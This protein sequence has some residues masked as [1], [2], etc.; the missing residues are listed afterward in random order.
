M[1]IKATCQCGFTVTAK[2]ALAGKRVACPRCQKALQIPK[3]AT[4]A[5]QAQTASPKIA[6]LLDDMGVK[7]VP[8]G[9]VCSACGEEMDATAVLCVNCGYNVTTGQY[10][11]TY[12]DEDGGDIHEEN[13]S[14]GERLVRQVEMELESG[15]PINETDDFGDGADSYLIA[16]AALFGLGMFVVIGLITVMAMEQM[17]SDIDAGLIGMWACSII[18]AVNWMWIT[19]VAL[20]THVSH[21]IACVGSLGL[22]C[23]I[24]GFFVGRGTKPASIFATVAALIGGGC[25]FY[26]YNFA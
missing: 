12:A 8:M 14:D 16:V 20:R 15:K 17:T 10:L 22:Y 19:L 1:P 2:D 3:L 11:E 6:S 7:A 5:A 25:A 24:Y 18:V 26:Y 21:G 4:V 9:P 13:V 23:I